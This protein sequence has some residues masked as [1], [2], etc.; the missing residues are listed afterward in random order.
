M[1]FK[2]AM[3]SLFQGIA[4]GHLFVSLIFIL[5]GEYNYLFVSGVGFVYLV[6][7]MEEE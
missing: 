1:S 4:I 6:C 2:Q 3:L 5:P 7:L